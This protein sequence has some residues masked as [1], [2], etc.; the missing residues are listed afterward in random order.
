M[1][2]GD[3]KTA[4]DQI[5]DDFKS[6][7]PS[8]KDS[9]DHA[10]FIKEWTRRWDTDFNTITYERFANVAVTVDSVDWVD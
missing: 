3:I 10:Q 2:E 8:V 4:G 7:G 1:R 5:T 6:F 9:S